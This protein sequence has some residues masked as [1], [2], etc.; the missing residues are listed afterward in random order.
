MVVAYCRRKNQSIYTA[1]AGE[2]VRFFAMADHEVAK[3]YDINE[4]V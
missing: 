3:E 2:A 1:A 4:D